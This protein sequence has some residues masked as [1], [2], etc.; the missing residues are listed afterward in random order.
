MISLSTIK[1]CFDQKNKLIV[2]F[3]VGFLLVG[4]SG[5]KAQSTDSPSDGFQIDTIIPNGYV[6]IP[7]KLLNAVSISAVMGSHGVADIYATVQGERSKLLFSKAKIIKSPTE[8]D[9]FAI[10]V[11]ESK[12]Y[13]LSN[14]ENP[15]FAAIQNPRARANYESEAAAPK[16]STVRIIYQN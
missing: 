9:S 12:A 5:L 11:K 13:L 8:E 10:L 7:I 14:S 1:Q 16:T 15:F 3:I 2:F 4:F 6:L